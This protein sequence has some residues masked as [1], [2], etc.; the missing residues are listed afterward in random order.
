[1][2]KYGFDLTGWNYSEAHLQKCTFKGAGSALR[3][4]GNVRHSLAIANYPL[5]QIYTQAHTAVDRLRDTSQTV[6]YVMEAA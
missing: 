2:S 1:M 6:G 4:S 5:T 3:H